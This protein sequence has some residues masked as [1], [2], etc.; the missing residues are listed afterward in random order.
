MSGGGEKQ[1]LARM[2]EITYIAA[3]AKDP[4]GGDGALRLLFD[5]VR[6]FCRSIELCD[7]YLRGYYGLKLVSF[8]V[9]W[10]GGISE[11]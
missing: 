2:G 10:G 9:P 6:W 5:S 4:S 7:G 11:V 3:M 8:I 1:I